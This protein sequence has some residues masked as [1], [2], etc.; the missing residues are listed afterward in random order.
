MKQRSGV[1]DSLELKTLFMMIEAAITSKI[2]TFKVPLIS[3]LAM[4]GRCM[5]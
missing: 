3:F 2:V 5:R 4:A 1:A